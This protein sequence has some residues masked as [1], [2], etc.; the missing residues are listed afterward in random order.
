L[1]RTQNSV[2]ELIASGAPLGEALLAVVRMVEE[3]SP[4]ALC[5]VLLVEGTRL[6]L[7]AAPSLPDAFN[8]AVDGIAIGEGSG[9]CGT[10]AA[11][12][13]VVVIE[14][15]TTDPLVVA[16]RELAAAHGIRAAWSV[17][18]IAASG[19]LLATFAT[20]HREV[21]RPSDAEMAW[22]DLAARLVRIAI[23]HERAVTRVHATE[24]LVRVAGQVARLGG[25]SFTR[26]DETVVW[27]DEVCRI[28]DVAP[29]TRPTVAAAIGCYAPEW[30]RPVGEAFARCLEAGQPYDLEA[31]IVTAS[32]RRAWV[33][34]IGQAVRGL[35]GTIRRVE[36]AFQDISE[37]KRADEERRRLANRLTET[38]ESI[39]DAVVLID[40]SWRFYYVNREAERLV[41]Q[42]REM[43]FGRTVWDAFPA[44][45]G[46]EFEVQ[47]RRAVAEHRSVH[48]EAFFGPLDA[49]FEV[50][51]HPS[52]QGLAVYFRNVTER[53]QA[54][55]RIAEQAALLDQARD[56]ILVRALDDTIVYWNKSAE[57]L[58]GY[59]A[60][61]AIGRNA[62]EIINDRS[63]EFDEA[64]R[65]LLATGEWTGTLRQVARSGAR[66]IVESRWTVVRDEAGEPRAVLAINTDITERRSLEQ[67]FLR[68]QRLES[69]GTLAGG[70]AHDL[71]NVLAPIMMSLE[72]MHEMVGPEG[73]DL[74]ESLH[75]NVRR[76]AELVRQVLTFARGLDG[77]REPVD[78]CAIVREIERVARDT[79]PKGIEIRGL[80]PEDRALVL[81][82]STQLHQVVMNLSVNA[83]DAMSDGGRLA[84]T[85]TPRRAFAPREAQTLGIAPGD[86]VTLT[87]ADTGVGI[88]DHLHELVFEPFYTTKEVGRGTGLGLSTLQSIL[89]S[90][91]GAV[92]LRSEPGMGAAF[93]CLLPAATG[94]D[95]RSEAREGPTPALPRTG[96]GRCV[97]VVDDEAP[98]RNVARRILERHGYR[99][100]LAAHGGEALERVAE[101]GDAVAAVICDVSMPVMDG[102][103]TVAALRKLRP[104]LP[105]IVSSGYMKDEGGAKLLGTGV[106][107]FITKPFTAETLLSALHAVLAAP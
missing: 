105:I 36:G 56:A 79:F 47:Y 7:G 83:R 69:I 46:S 51:A 2:L 72:L 48:F 4:G 89:R 73:V 92:Q 45:V 6:R 91:G 43:L 8:A 63:T 33:R 35:D 60:G 103:A 25:W 102:P 75:G 21:H 61:E 38:L 65:E 18:V 104:S 55:A 82:D 11:R 88:P 16:Y 100:V 86:Y 27:S 44:T 53:R 37:F 54:V 12:R 90:H 41:G 39:S 78:L 13:A 23:E 96:G 93:T 80:A 101:E 29:G 106:E 70:I 19:E 74:I 76:G 24:A 66:L 32:G 97:L 49:W 84:F 34:A 81:G 26:G 58:Y 10:A 85:V 30:R 31:E 107:H 57:R 14:D 17:P 1:D 15:V 98:I 71:N 22:V 94:D 42:T 64:K 9:I 28:H 20:Y 68:A 52:E 67:Q 59:S 77:K 40:T 5:S 95:E 87:V 99:V 3:R 50:H 62:R